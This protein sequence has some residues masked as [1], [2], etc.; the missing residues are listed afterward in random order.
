MGALT[1]QLGVF[2]FQ[3]INHAGHGVDGI[4]PE[5]RRGA[6]RGLALGGEPPPKIAFVG[7]DGLQHG[8]LAGDG[9]GALGAGLGKFPRAGL[10]AFLIHETD[11]QQFSMLRS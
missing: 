10:V 7:G 5:M 8:R 2:G 9:E 11:K 3:H 4:F 6:V 1:Q